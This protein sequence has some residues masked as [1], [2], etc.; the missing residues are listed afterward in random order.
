MQL[1][2]KLDVPPEPEETPDGF[3]EEPPEQRREESEEDAT[4]AKDEPGRDGE[5]VTLEQRVPPTTNPPEDAY[6]VPALPEEPS[7]YEGSDE[8][9]DGGDEQDDVTRAYLRASAITFKDALGNEIPLNAP[10][11]AEMAGYLSARKLVPDIATGSLRALD[12]LL[13]GEQYEK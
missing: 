1:E 2:D 10:T 13:W 6:A 4:P 11:R 12:L 8:Q 7:P 5:P 3:P 9:D